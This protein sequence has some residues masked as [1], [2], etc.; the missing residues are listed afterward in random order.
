MK[1]MIPRAVGF[2]ALIACAGAAQAHTGH[3]TSGLGA[4]LLHPFGADHLLAMVAVGM[5][6]VSALP[7]R[8]AW[9][10]PAS[11]M[12]ALTAGAALGAAGL[13]LP[14]VEAAVALSVAVFGA[15]LVLPSRLP[16]VAGLV[17]IAAA[18]LLHGMA[19]GAE[20]PASGFAAYAA[21]FLTMT[22]LLHGTG[23]LAGLS[24]RRHLS[25]AAGFAHAG[26]AAVCGA[27]GLYLFSQV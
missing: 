4:G 20:A 16:R 1:W 12:L 22:A 27:T 10:G 13:A 8:Q 5:W 24:L 9:W 18:A 7:G 6:S 14:F 15:M 2:G 11:F 3:G 21:G 19:H 23:M 25:G 17:V 26:L